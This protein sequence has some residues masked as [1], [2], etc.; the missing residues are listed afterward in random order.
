MPLD[1][2]ISHSVVNAC[3][4]NNPSGEESGLNI[5]DESDDEETIDV[6]ESYETKV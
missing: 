6:E 1:V 5:S 2:T 3:I 4:S